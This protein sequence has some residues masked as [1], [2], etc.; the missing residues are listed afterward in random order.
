MTIPPFPRHADLHVA[1]LIVLF[2]QLSPATLDALAE[3]YA[4]HGRFKDP[5][6]DARGRAAIRR[7]YAHM[8]DALG[9]PRFTI[10]HALGGGSDCVLTWRLDCT[11]RGR[12]LAI[13]GAS[14]LQ[15]D[16]AGRITDH[17]DYWDTAEEL[18]AKLPLLG[19]LVRALQR[20]L[21]TPGP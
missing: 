19:P 9:A 6:N 13:H 17:R 16:A 10:Q 18:F 4:E 7:V 5:F 21:A 12:P 15:L 8:F 2:E 20:R 11:L 3:R 14:R 1:T